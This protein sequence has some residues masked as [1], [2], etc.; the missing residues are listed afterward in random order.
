MSCTTQF[1]VRLATALAVF[2]A[3]A[4]FAP[5]GSAAG[6]PGSAQVD[7]PALHQQ[8]LAAVNRGDA[9]TASALFVE[10]ALYEGG[11]ACTPFCRGRD[12]L[13][14]E[15]QSLVDEHT[16]I[17][18]TSVRASTTSMTRWLTTWNE[19]RS[20][21]VRAAAVERALSATTLGA[22]DGSIVFFITQW[23]RTDAQTN[24]F[25]T[26]PTESSTPPESA[27][28]TPARSTPEPYGR[29]VDIGGRRLY[30][31]CL[32][33]GSPTVVLE[34]GLN[35]GAGASRGLWNHSAFAPHVTIQRDLAEMTRVCAYDRA[36]YGLSDPGPTP[37]TAVGIADDLHA[38]LRTASVEPPYVLAGISFGGPI[39]QVYASRFPEDV[40]G[41]VEI[42]PSPLVDQEERI[43]ALLPPAIASR[44]R[45]RI[46][47]ENA[48]MASPQGPGGGTDMDTFLAQVRQA[49]TVPHVPLV[50][51]TAVASPA[52][53]PLSWP[54]DFSHEVIEQIN[55]VRVE[56]QAAIARLPRTGK[57]VLVDNSDHA[58]N[59]YAPQAI[60]DAIMRVLQASRLA[61][62]P[63]IVEY[64]V[65]TPDSRPGGIVVGPDGYLWFIESIGNNLGRISANAQV[66]E[67]PIPTTNANLPNQA[68]V[69]IG[70]DGMVWFTES[71]ANKIGRIT[72]AGEI[73]EFD[74]PS[75]AMR[76]DPALGAVRTSFPIAITGGPDG[77]VWFNE[78]DTNRI[79]RMTLDGRFTEF[80]IPDGVGGLT[81]LISGPDGALWFVANTPGHIGRITTDGDITAFAIP[82]PNAA[83]IRLKVG[84][85][86]AIWFAENRANKIGRVTM[87]GRVTEFPLPAQGVGPD[88]APGPDGAMWFTVFTDNQIG[89]ITGTGDVTLYPV[90][91]AL[92]QPYWLVEGPDHAIW[93]T[94]LGGNRIGRAS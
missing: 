70:P 2:A 49:T 37:H 23:D 15:M 6:S 93:F 13:R 31:E 43:Q 7:L 41:I 35:S 90:P 50:V 9:D 14:R 91:T 24:A 12:A 10:D 86:G 73:T 89:R 25:L 94:E 45:A 26:P 16:Q 52:T 48:S 27:A 28:A 92:S 32:G 18:S 78:R 3:Q 65:P 68:F 57:H 87:D 47:R 61:S 64:D 34:G 4:P 21:A 66:T 80:P 17:T 5:L 29:L 76:E 79:A 20:D 42:D 38:L 84:P 54:P 39:V 71:A 40:A 46:E 69:G 67:F 8:W 75:A 56:S 55:E 83:A 81:G 36:G 77:A 51:L 60:T 82:T 44:R 33:Q 1:V 22:R 53:N 59:V 72:P 63:H 88:I 11:A 85:D 30:L 62:G 19:V 74:I 58:M